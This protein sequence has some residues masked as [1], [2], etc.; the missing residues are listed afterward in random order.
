MTKISLSNLDDFIDKYPRNFLN[1][2]VAEQ[3]MTGIA[4]GLA[5]EGR[6]V[7]TYSIANFTI[8]RCLEQ[9]R[10]DACYHQANVNV[11]SVGGGFSYGSLGFSHHA[12]EDLAIMRSI[13]E[14]SVFSPCGHWEVE[15]LT[16]Q[17]INHPGT[18]Y[19]RLDKS[20]GVDTPIY[21]NEIFEIGKPRI[22]KEGFNWSPQMS[23]QAF[24]VVGIVAMLVQGG[25]IGPLVS[26]FGEWRLT[27]AG[28]GFVIAGCILLTLA[29]K[30]NSIPMVFSAVAILAVGTGLVTPC[31][32]ALISKRLDAAGQGAVLGSLQGLQSLGT[33]LGA[34][35]AGLS[36]DLLGQRSPFFG[37]T[38]L[39]IF[40]LTLISG[41]D[42]PKDKKAISA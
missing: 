30:E 10:N 17:I 8:L 15:E 22:L 9:I 35:A 36:Y 37:T 18:C 24:V 31:L 6:I 2:G 3:N 20:V 12:T 19:L 25:F 28:I 16:K 21:E 14:I 4:T 32:R 5:L 40:V 11:V 29:N 26:R 41:I 38:I 27:M 1:A 7:F 42:L 23:S 33:F 39:L 13:P 34:T